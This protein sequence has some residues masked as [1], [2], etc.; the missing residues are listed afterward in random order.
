MQIN[1]RMS[2]YLYAM[3][4]KEND[5]VYLR[6]FA[7]DVR[8]GPFYSVPKPFW[9]PDKHPHLKIDIDKVSDDIQNDQR[10][11]IRIKKIGKDGKLSR[12]AAV[13]LNEK[14]EFIVN[15]SVLELEKK[16]GEPAEASRTSPANENLTVSQLDKVFGMFSGRNRPNSFHNLNHLNLKSNLSLFLFELKPDRR[17]VG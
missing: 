10:R 5:Q 16:G 11:S 14:D 7:F 17:I 13:Y 3:C 4:Y 8:N 2:E 12:L 6:K 1:V 15:G 9:A